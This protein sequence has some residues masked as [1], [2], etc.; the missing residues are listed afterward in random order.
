[1]V[2]NELERL[3]VWDRYFRYIPN[4][5]EADYTIEL[6]NANYHVLNPGDLLANS[7][8]RFATAG[9]IDTD[10]VSELMRCSIRDKNGDIRYKKDFMAYSYE[11]ENYEEKDSSYEKERIRR[12]NEYQRE[13]AR[14][15]SIS[16]VA[17]KIY[18]L[19]KEHV[20]I[21]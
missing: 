18:K 12:E 9:F 3:I 2:K 7:L 8:I 5:A 10:D 16:P 1:M 4:E 17:E 6:K 21:R 20:D 19:L 11:E 13:K 15:A 14:N